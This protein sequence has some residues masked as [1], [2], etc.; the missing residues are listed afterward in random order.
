M[1]EQQ[2]NKIF[3]HLKKIIKKEPLEKPNCT[4]CGEEI[5]NG[6]VI[7]EEGLP[8]IH[9]LPCYLHIL[10]NMNDEKVKQWLKD[11]NKLLKAIAI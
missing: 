6:P 5:E 9:A 10:E 2:R 8:E 4:F 11:Q 7:F 1:N 3:G